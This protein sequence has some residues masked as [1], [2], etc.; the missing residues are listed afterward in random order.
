MKFLAYGFFRSKGGVLNNFN[1][2]LSPEEYRVRRSKIIETRAIELLDLLAPFPT[3]S[4]LVSVGATGDGCYMMTERDIK[5]AKYLIS[6][7]IED[8]N[9]FEIELADLGINGIQVDNSIKVPP[10]THKNL[11]FLHGTLG[12]GNRETFSINQHLSETPLSNVVLKLDIEG[13]EY[14]VINEIN[15]SNLRKISSIVIE[16]HNLDLIY[17]DSFWN[18]V[19]N[20]L[21]KLKK[22]ELFPCFVSANNATSA[23][24]LGGVLIPRNLEVTF[25]R[26]VNLKSKFDSSDLKRIGTY[27][28]VNDVNLSSVNID[29]LIFR[30]ACRNV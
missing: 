9:S 30:K 12:L 28:T 15:P 10:V 18:Q 3:K 11:H 25:T 17:K 6:G 1:S 23:E 29:H 21:K 13:A 8:N 22:A 4:H 26:K 2:L 14:D 7:G 19:C 20:M 24:I 27:L 5:S 16:L